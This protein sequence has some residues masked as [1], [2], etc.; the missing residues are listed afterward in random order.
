M[1]NLAGWGTTDEDNTIS[2][3]ILQ[4]AHVSI[5]DDAT[6]AQ[7][8]AATTRPT[9]TCAGEY[10]TAGA[11][12]G[13]SGG[14]L[15]VLDA[16]GTPHLW[17]LTSYGPARPASY[18]EC[19]LRIPVIFTWVP[20][21]AGW[22]D[23]TL[24]GLPW[25][26]PREDPRPGPGPGP[27]PGRPPRRHEAARAV[28]GQAQHEADQAGEARRDDRP[29]GGRRSS[30]SSS[31][32]RRRSPWACARAASSAAAWPTFAADAGQDDE[33]LLRPRGRQEAQARP[34]QAARLRRRRGGQRGAVED[35]RLQ[36]RLSGRAARAAT[37]CSVDERALTER[38]ITY[39]TSQPDGIRACAGLHQ[40]L[41]GGARDRRPRQ[42]LRRAAG[43]HRLRRAA[44]RADDHPPRAPR[45]RA[46]PR[47]AVHAAD[48]GRPAVRPR[49][50]RHEG[51]RSPR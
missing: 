49:R 22:I 32:S 36:G 47:G 18:K 23:A 4:D 40:G 24:A 26:P 14:P 1:T 39:D 37:L 11:C 25:P 41:A 30:P 16:A 19:D 31:T 3:D 12:H 51:R 5:V 35:A 15:T 45:R 7:F 38:L 2:T 6:C 42:R 27:G 34:V 48:R 21:F 8:D 33:A 10:Q 9:Q 17:G 13:D 43:A 44:R 46:R 50:L 29:Q 28:R 20:A